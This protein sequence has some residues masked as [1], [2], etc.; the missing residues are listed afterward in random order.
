M[1]SAAGMVELQNGCACCS[2]SEE[3]LASVAELVT[4]SD[5]RGDSDSFQHIVVEMSGVADPKSVRAKFQEAEVYDMPLLER[6]RLDTMITVVDSNMFLE[7]MNS[8][9][10]ATP[11]DAPEL[12][13]RDGE[14]PQEEDPYLQSSLLSILGAGPTVGNDGSVADLIVSQVETADVVL[15]NKV[16]LSNEQNLAQ[17]S[18]IVE[19]LNGRATIIRTIFGD[20]PLKSVLGVAQGQ[21]VVQAGLVDDHKD[22]V[23]AAT[24]HDPDCND[25]SHRHSHKPSTDSS[26]DSDSNNHSHSHDHSC[27]D[28]NC[29]DSAHDHDHDHKEN[30]ATH[31]GIGTFVYRARRPFHPGR[32]LTFLR[33]MPL[34]RGLPED[35]LYEITSLRPFSEATNQVLSRVMRSKGFAWLADSDLAATYWSSAGSSFEMTTL[36]SWWATLPRDQW[37]QGATHV[38][39][40]DFDSNDHDESDSSFKTVGDRRQ[41]I[42]FIGPTLGEKG[43]QEIISNALDLCLLNDLEW[44]QY[45]TNRSEENVLQ[46]LFPSSINSKVI[47]F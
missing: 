40:Q 35:A 22:A 29:L 16:D 18:S 45:I 7:Y 24:C 34:K 47:T 2:K 23:H 3:L 9:K 44:N 38:I 8:S 6:V 14:V 25:P 41:E 31:A 32:I 13:Y 42:V 27:N 33:N 15:L 36:G 26:R 4:L 30:G 10:D 1:N 20:V 19:A 5:M 39:L 37:P 28:P 43:N 11:D 17:V 21:G 46:R 12:Y